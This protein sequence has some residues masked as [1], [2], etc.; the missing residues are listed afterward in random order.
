MAFWCSR[1]LAR[2]LS[3]SPFLPRFSSFLGSSPCCRLPFRLVFFSLL[4]SCAPAR[5][6][7]P[8]ALCASPAAASH[9]LISPSA[10]PR[11]SLLDLD[12]IV[13]LVCPT[14]STNRHALA[15]SPVPPCHETERDPALE[16]SSVLHSALRACAA[17]THAAASCP[18]APCSS[19]HDTHTGACFFLLRPATTCYYRLPYCYST[20]ATWSDLRYQLVTAT[21]SADRIQ[22]FECKLQRLA[23]V[24][25]L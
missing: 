13:T 8:A 15:I 17:R 5:S 12:L 24:S 21:C 3:R 20:G 19:R 22:L 2:R 25:V 9:P 11:P 14:A 1:P 6:P 7:L 18:L 4:R 10:S 16:P 23:L